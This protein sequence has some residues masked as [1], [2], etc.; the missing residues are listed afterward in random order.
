MNLTNFLLTPDAVHFEYFG[1]EF[2]GDL[3]MGI[4]ILI[5]FSI[6]VLVYYKNKRN[7]PKLNAIKEKRLE[8]VKLLEKFNLEINQQQIILEHGEISGDYLF[9]PLTWGKVANIFTINYKLF[10]KKIR[11]DMQIVYSIMHDLEGKDID[12]TQLI[13]IDRL[14]CT[15]IKIRQNLAES[16]KE[17]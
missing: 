7:Q 4:I 11:K 15:L 14:N 3:I 2:R 8:F 17:L 12:H 6:G 10:N 1:I 13:P 9:N 5:I 16:Y